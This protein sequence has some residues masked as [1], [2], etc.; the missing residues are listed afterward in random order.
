MSIPAPMEITI[1]MTNGFL[2]NPV[3][4]AT[5]TS[6]LIFYLSLSRSERVFRL[7]TIS[8]L[9]VVNTAGL[10]L[11]L[12]NVLQCHPL[13]AVFQDIIPV[14]AICTDIVTLYLSSAP[15]NIIT[16][17]S[18]LF[19]PMP[20]LTA[21]RLPRKQKIILIIT[22]SFGAFSA[23]VDVVRIAYLQEA[24]QVRIDEVGAQNATSSRVLEQ[25]D[26]S[27]YASLSFMW[28]AIEVHVGIICACVPSLKPLVARILPSMLR[29]VNNPNDNSGMRQGSGT[30]DVRFQTPDF[31][32]VPENLEVLPGSTGAPFAKS[33]RKESIEHSPTRRSI[34]ASPGRGSAPEM[35]MI[36]FLETTDGRPSDARRPTRTTM[37]TGSVATTRR[38]STAFFDFYTLRTKKPMTKLSN[39]ESYGPLALVTILF[40]MW[41]FAYGLLDVLNTQ[42]QEVVNMSA[43]QA[44]GLHAAYYG[45]YFIGPPT[46]GRVVFKKYG[47][48][49]T[50]ITGL[51]IYG[52]G[53]LVFWPSAV[54]LSYGAFIVSNLIVGF[55]VS[56]LEV[57]ANPFIALCGPPRHAETRLSISQGV[58][59]IGTIIAP[60]LAK[61]V[62]FKDVINASALIDVQWTYL[63]IALFDVVLS[64]IFVYMPLP[65]ASDRDFERVAE[66]RSNVNSAPLF[67]NV[68]V[69]YIT[70]ALGV[71][72]N[73]F[74]CAAQET[75]SVEY[76]SYISLV[77][78]K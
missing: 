34:P 23:A 39:R 4:M 26:F 11:T 35:S 24:F 45:G 20:I 63:G 7:A 56:T 21:M 47:F 8:T 25:D 54:L 29:D 75:A 68:K 12:L 48:K 36:D 40:F 53:T 66:K 51:C 1:G 50:F 70:L 59:A 74:Y 41:G 67:G 61:K 64:V 60:L 69:V 31:V 42:F 77:L 76:Q 44:V 28:S 65:E 5:K 55:G 2:Q 13:W 43:G 14:Y 58:Q 17:L 32:T 38:A 37:G 3:L 62:L 49:A 19:L 33:E 78:P 15:V 73:F 52:I 9:V 6:I 18:I 46:V 16:D 72:S 71:M 57:A 27:W 10:A 30:E 22:F